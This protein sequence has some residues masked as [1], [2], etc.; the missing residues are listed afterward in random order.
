[1]IISVSGESCTGKTSFLRE[2]AAL[3]YHV[4]SP[5]AS[6]IAS[7]MHFIN[8]EAKDKFILEEMGRQIEESAGK[9]LVFLDRSAVD[10]LSWRM[11]SENMTARVALM[12]YPDAAKQISCLDYVCLMVRDFPIADDGVRPV[13]PAFLEKWAAAFRELLDVCS[14]P[15]C[16]FRGPTSARVTYLIDDVLPGV[17]K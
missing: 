9:E 1:M 13:D 8:Q 2:L 12:E 11:V 7:G 14:I 3:G 17:L 10:Q 4:V 15:H 5:S 6:R 16:E